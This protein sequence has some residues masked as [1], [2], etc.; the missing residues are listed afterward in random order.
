M[1]AMQK[2]FP[3]ADV[4]SIITGKLICDISGIYEVIDW[5]FDCN[6]FTHQLPDASLVAKKLILSEHPQLQEAIVE[7][8][9][10]NKNNWK[11]YRALWIERYGE[12]IS[13]SKNNTHERFED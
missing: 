5:I 12:N 2:E 10:V 11:T 1:G 3:I 7:S 6:A 13:I 8:E 9:N 4:L